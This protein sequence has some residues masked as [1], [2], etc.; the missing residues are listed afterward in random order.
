MNIKLRINDIL[1][2][3]D[4]DLTVT[5]LTSGDYYKM[6]F[7]YNK[8]AEINPAQ[9]TL[10]IQFKNENEDIVTTIA[11]DEQG[12]KFEVVPENGYFEIEMPKLLFREGDYTFSYMISEKPSFNTPHII[13]DYLDNVMSI[14]VNRGD[15]WN[16]GI[17]NRPKGFIQDS[18]IKLIQC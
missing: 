10:V 8:T 15:F 14:K 11:T 12:T 16:S 7:L 6:R 9:L 3:N 1:F 17:L 13:M 18:S 5:E 4:S 2:K